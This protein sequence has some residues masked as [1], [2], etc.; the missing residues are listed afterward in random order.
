MEKN[1]TKALQH[2]INASDLSHQFSCMGNG[3]PLSV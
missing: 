2:N 3:T 1:L